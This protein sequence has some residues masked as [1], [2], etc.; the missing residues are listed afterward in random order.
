MNN[1]HSVLQLTRTKSFPSTVT[2]RSILDKQ[3][4]EEVREELLEALGS[5]P[6]TASWLEGSLGPH[7]ALSGSSESYM[8]LIATLQLTNSCNLNCSFC[9]ASSGR[10]FNDELNPAQWINLLE[11][12]SIG[13]LMSVTLSGGEPTLARGFPQVLEAASALINTVD[14]FTNGMAWLDK[15]VEL[16]AA[17]GNV[18]C[19]VSIDGLERNHDLLR[20]RE[21]SYE[22]AIG[23]IKRLS[24]AGVHVMTAMTVTPANYRDLEKVIYKWV[25]AE[26]C[27]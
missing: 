22:L 11:K 1:S 21:G 20:G 26:A 15:T 17:L 5:H 27:G 25:Y 6:F 23:T 3:P 7:L 18:R 16:V 4:I 9:Y 8:P 2:A 24:D 10:A 14:I 13:G 19:Q 12:L